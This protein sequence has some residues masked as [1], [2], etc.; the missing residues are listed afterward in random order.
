MKKHF[1]SSKGFTLIELLVVIAVLGVLAATVLVA[2]DPVE[3]LARGRDTG[4]KSAI[5]E[6]GRAMTA[7]GTSRNGLYLNPAIGN[8]TF[9]TDL[10]NAGEIK[11]LPTRSIAI[12]GCS[13]TTAGK[14]LQND[15][16][17]STDATATSFAVY[18]TPES[19]SVK[20]LCPTEAL[21]IAWYVY[22]SVDGR[23]GVVCTAAVTA[24]PEVD[25]QTFVGP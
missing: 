5:A 25:T 17:Y 3:Q 9:L 12:A 15:F 2:I 10:K 4:M 16:C 8:I 21:P 22:S 19:K 18:A 13:L 7:Y 24:E 23:A 11:T 6:I 1:L 20:N 14:S